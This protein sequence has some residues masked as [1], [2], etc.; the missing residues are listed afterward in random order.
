MRRTRVFDDDASLLLLF[1]F[2]STQDDLAI[3]IEG[4]D[5]RYYLQAGAVLIP[6]PF[7]PFSFSPSSP[8]FFFYFPR[9]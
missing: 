8:V 7:L 6:G 1:A 3:M 2:L 5:G 9:F 4:T